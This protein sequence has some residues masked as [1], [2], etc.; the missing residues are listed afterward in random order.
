MDTTEQYIKMCEKAEEIQLLRREERHKDTG[1]WQEG[2][3]WR[4]VFRFDKGAYVVSR[5]SDAWADEPF[6]LHHPP[7]SIWLPRQDQLQE[8]ASA[9]NLQDLF[10][11]FLN[12]YSE[13]KDHPNLDEDGGYWEM[14]EY[15]KHFTSM[16]QLWLAFVM[17]VKYGK[18]WDGE[19]WQTER[20]QNETTVL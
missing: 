7:E 19:K 14:F 5:P 3:F 15:G 11:L 18:I 1:K 16:E 2:D 8:M 10:E 12:F 20:R 6:Y 13:Y 17:S 4:T 9:T